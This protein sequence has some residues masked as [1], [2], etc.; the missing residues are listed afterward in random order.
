[1]KDAANTASP[2]IDIC[3]LDKT[4]QY[5]V[6]CGRSLGEIASWRTASDN[7]RRAITQKLPERLRRL[8]I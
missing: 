5:C 8:K 4:G 1:M 2:C 7:E 3:D 6:G